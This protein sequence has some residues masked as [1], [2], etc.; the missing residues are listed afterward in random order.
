MLRVLF[1][2]FLVAHG[3]IHT[4]F[5]TRAPTPAPGAPEWPF[6]MSRSWLITGIGLDEGVVRSMGVA[7]VVITVVAFAASGIAWFGLVVPAAW[8]PTLVVIGSVASIALLAGFFHPWLVVGFA[9][10][11]ALIYLAAGAGW[12]AEPGAAT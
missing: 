4:G 1:G 12:S 9:I 10:D 7:L 3:L 11:L 6:A 2:L 8:W 5:V